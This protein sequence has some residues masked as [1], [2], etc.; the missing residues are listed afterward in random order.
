MLPALLKVSHTLGGGRSV[1]R[2]VFPILVPSTASVRGRISPAYTPYTRQELRGVA[3]SLPS[4]A[5]SPSQAVSGPPASREG[6][7]GTVPPQENTSGN[8]PR[9]DETRAHRG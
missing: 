7:G 3:S 8:R 4:V 6:T 9:T 2:V 5:L 1:G